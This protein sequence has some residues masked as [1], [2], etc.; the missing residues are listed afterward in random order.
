MASRGCGTFSSCAVEDAPHRSTRMMFTTNKA[1]TQR[2]GL[3]ADAEATV[4][5]AQPALQRSPGADAMPT[6]AAH[7]RACEHK[8]MRRPTHYH[9][10]GYCCVGHMHGS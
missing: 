5:A 9:F 2:G 8:G 6:A 1:S 3:S 10:H 7:V 4:V